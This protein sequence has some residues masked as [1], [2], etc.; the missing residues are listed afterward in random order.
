MPDETWKFLFG[1]E[2]I[3]MT[4]DCRYLDKYDARNVSYGLLQAVR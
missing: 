3:S 1:Y 4:S 2:S